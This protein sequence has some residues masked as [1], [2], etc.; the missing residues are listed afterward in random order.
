MTVAFSYHVV[1]QDYY[2]KAYY[3]KI[4]A[5]TRLQKYGKKLFCKVNIRKKSTSAEKKVT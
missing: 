2:T 3:L 1:K 5:N 4:I